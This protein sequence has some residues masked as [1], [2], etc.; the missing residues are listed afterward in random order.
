MILSKKSFRGWMWN[1]AKEHAKRMQILKICNFFA[2]NG[3]DVKFDYCLT[4]AKS[5]CLRLNRHGWDTGQFVTNVTWRL[6]H[7]NAFITTAC[8]LSLKASLCK[9]HSS[10]ALLP[11]ICQVKHWSCSKHMTG[12]FWDVMSMLV[13]GSICIILST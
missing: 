6:W 8:Q 4:V 11:R 2:Q 7:N 5:E 12:V 1:C 9:L 3:I 10:A 13:P